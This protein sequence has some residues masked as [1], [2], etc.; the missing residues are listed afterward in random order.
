MTSARTL[1]ACLPPTELCVCQGPAAV[2]AHP[3]LGGHCWD[4]PVLLLLPRGVGWSRGSE[5]GAFNLGAPHPTW[6]ESRLEF[7][8]G[9]CPLPVLPPW[10][11]TRPGSGGVTK[12]K[13]WLESSTTFRLVWL[14]I[15]SPP[16]RKPLW[17]SLR[18]KLEGR[19]I[20]LVGQE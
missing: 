5:R 16:S 9:V 3:R 4:T 6:D 15:S 13:L 17:R 14:G 7:W 18:K 2:P 8:L 11:E 10:G 19:S 12:P 20:G 1:L